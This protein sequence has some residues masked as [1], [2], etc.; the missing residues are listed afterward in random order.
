M[1]PASD[2]RLG[3]APWSAAPPDPRRRLALRVLLMLALPLAVWY[4]G[5]LVS[6]QRIGNP[7]LYGLL[8]A[9]E[10][11]N[12]IQAV[13]FWLTLARD[14]P[15]PDPGPPPAGAEVDVLV[16]VYDEPVEIVEP[17]VAAALRLRGARVNVAV[18]DDGDREEMAALARRLGARYVRRDEHEGAKAGNVNHALGVTS[19]P[20]VLV[21]D[22]DHVP[23]DHFLEATLGHLADERVA[24][25]QTP[26]CYANAPDG[27]IAAASWA[28]QALFFG[29]IARGK[30][31]WGAMFCAGTNVVFRRSA[32]EE[33]GGFP[34]TSLTEDFELSVV[35]HERGW[36]TVY[37]P[38]VLALGVGP[39]DMASYV[40]QQQRWARGCLGG[41]ASAL[42]A[43]LPLGMRVQYLLSGMYFL[44][45]W[46]V[47][48]YMSFPVV[49]ILTGEQPLDGASAD[50]FLLHFVPYF[51]VA[52]A[53]V[54]V[55]GG[56]AYT[57]QAFALTW[58]NAW[59]H[60]QAS[61]RALLRVRGRFVVTPK[62]GGWRRQPRTVLPALV[63]FA[64]LVGVSVYGIVRD[65]SPA[66]LNNAA[67][68]ALHA[69]V[70]LTG[71]SLALV[72]PVAPRGPSAPPEASSP[73]RAAAAAPAAR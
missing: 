73:D 33:V 5:W 43:R 8:I 12:L 18:L 45:G 65:P 49:R 26:Q 16:P 69:A 15:R 19:A 17:V 62:E 14:R 22:S 61:L 59:I 30:D 23:R 41:M 53:T 71:A 34:L 68:A 36:R 52:L 72:R 42:R 57:F 27:G 4:F 25:V 35:M 10:L 70:L 2:P 44:S 54:A 64:V 11:F 55:A 46:T 37:V 20:Y 48:I 7:V 21:L 51:T 39:E 13:G 47:L 58:A 50:Q 40:S 28:Q 24:F 32:L 38:E 1:S 6:P 29:A 67:F 9:A 63:L 56:G 66:V 3:P 31:G 60:V